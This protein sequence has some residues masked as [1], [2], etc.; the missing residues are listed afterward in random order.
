MFITAKEE[1]GIFLEFKNNGRLA[2]VFIFT[3]DPTDKDVK[4]KKNK[5]SMLMHSE[6]C[7]RKCRKIKATE[8]DLEL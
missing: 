6:S 3:T 5:S 7:R 8:S 4:R 2:I 1:A